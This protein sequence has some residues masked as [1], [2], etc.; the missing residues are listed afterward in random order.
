MWHWFGCLSSSERSCH[1]QGN[2]PCGLKVTL[3]CGLNVTLPC[4]L[5]VKKCP[6]KVWETFCV[7]NVL[8]SQQ[9]TRHKWFYSKSTNLGFLHNRRGEVGQARDKT[10]H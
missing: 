5:N 1:V 10:V 2:A 8:V 4:G 7:I 3:P 6:F 9:R